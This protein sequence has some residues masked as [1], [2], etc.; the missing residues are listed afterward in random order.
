MSL[1]IAGVSVALLAMV[2]GVSVVRGRR[3]GTG[4]TPG[5]GGA[6]PVVVPGSTTSASP[7]RTADEGGVEWPDPG[8]RPRI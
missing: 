5:P 1:V 6:A 2:G 3:P 4:E 7:A 8:N